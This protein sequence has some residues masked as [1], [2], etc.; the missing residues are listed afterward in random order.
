MHG[1]T[2]AG[3]KPLGKLTFKRCQY[4]GPTP[5]EKRGYYTL[6]HW[7]KASGLTTAPASEPGS[8]QASSVTLKKSTYYR[9]K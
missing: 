4:H 2:E 1:Q 8:E 3:I 7:S 5:D 9:K 6:L